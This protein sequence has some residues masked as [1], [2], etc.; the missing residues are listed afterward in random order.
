[1]SKTSIP[2]RILIYDP[3][4]DR[5]EVQALKEK[6]HEIVPL[7][8]PYDLILHP[9]AH[10]WDETMFGRPQYLETALKAARRVRVESA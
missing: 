10:W 3:W 7:G 2:L 9:N 5:P 4:W 6:G 1:M 8:G